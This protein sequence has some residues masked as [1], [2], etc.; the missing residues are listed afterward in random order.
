MLGAVPFLWKR[1][2][3]A[4]LPAVHPAVPFFP[5]LFPALSPALLGISDLGFLS[6][7]AGGCDSCLRGKIGQIIPQREIFPLG[8]RHRWPSTGVK[9]PLPRKL[10]K[11]SAKGFPGALGLGVEKAQKKSKKS[12]KKIGKLSFS[13]LFRVFWTPGPRG[14][15]N[16]FSDF[17]RTFLGRGLFDSCGMPLMSQL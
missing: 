14:P 15:G 4:L 1:R 7:V 11:K 16:P 3:T 8:L 2:E 13:T 10:R 6:P 12:R 17:F 9:R 5:A